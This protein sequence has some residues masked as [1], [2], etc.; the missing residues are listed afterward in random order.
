MTSRPWGVYVHVPWC[1][2]RCPY[3]AFHV[4]VARGI[5]VEAY[6]QRVLALYAARQPEFGDAPHTL[7]LGGGTPSQLPTDA[8]ARIIS[9]IRGPDTVEVTVEAN[10][11]DVSEGFVDAL[12]AAGV[13][14]ISLGIQTLQ[15]THAR[16]LGRAYTPDHARRAASILASAGLRTWSADLMFALHAQTEAE[17][18]ADVEALLALSP[19]HVSLYGL[20]IEPRTAYARGVARGRLQPADDETWRRMYG[21]LVHTLEEAGLCRYEVSNFAREGHRSA[22]NQGYW[23]DRPYLGIGPSAHGYAPDGARWVDVADTQA[24]LTADDPVSEREHPMGE[25]AAMDR[26]IAGMR[27][28]AGLSLEALATQ[29]GFLPDAPTRQRLARGGVLQERD[30][31]MMLTSDGFYVADAVV[32]ALIDALAPVAH[33][34]AIR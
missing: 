30:G 4:D 31:R 11:E 27:G 32:A 19:P 28:T 15:P 6:V 16:S 10:P 20:T 7:Y 13:D 2:I 18:H 22:H 34:E 8:L 17:L 23:Q 1:R 5:P 21:H 33:G 9:A 26:L 29:T 24:W 3:C 12:L 14:R 25:E